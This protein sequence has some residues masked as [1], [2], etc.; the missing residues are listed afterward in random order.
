MKK[1]VV[2]LLFTVCVHGV[3][4]FEEIQTESDDPSPPPPEED[5]AA[6]ALLEEEE[7]E[8]DWSPFE[9][10]DMM[11]DEEE[12]RQLNYTEQDD[13]QPE[14]SDMSEPPFEEGEVHPDWISLA[15]AFEGD[16]ILTEEQQRQL[17][18]T[19]PER[20][21]IRKRSQLWA[22]GVIPYVISS[23]FSKKDRRI[24]YG[25]FGEYRKRTCLRFVKRSRQKAYISIVRRAGC[26]SMI[27][28][29]GRKQ[30]VSLGYGCVGKSIVIHELMH[31]TGFFHEQ[32]RY[33]RDRYVRI[34]WGNIRNNAKGNFK[35]ESKK[36]IQ[37]LG[38]PYDMNSVMHYYD[39]AFSKNGRKTIQ[40]RDGKNI[41]FR[42]SKG[43]SRIDVRK[44]NKLY[45][46]SSKVSC[47]D[48]NQYCRAWA[49]AKYCTRGKFIKYMKTSCKKSCNKC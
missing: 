37:L 2:V 32:S 36:N 40:R 4:P 22:K 29:T 35:K 19:S 47:S 26:H 9:G 1:L 42:Q 25:A 11:L 49:K 15:G 23:S 30:E 6:E 21:A 14:E 3:F 27:G 7:A 10:E 45:R 8:P 43:F 44:L 34:N 5:L 20:N 18:D 17:N 13:T 39:K 31:A 12:Q 38:E 46:C 41:Q 28:R 16:I 24:I 48:K 33:D